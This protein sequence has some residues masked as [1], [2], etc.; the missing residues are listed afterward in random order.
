MNSF[1]F[2][3]QWYSHSLVVFIHDKVWYNVVRKGYGQLKELTTKE[4]ESLR[5]SRL[6][7]ERRRVVEHDNRSTGGARRRGE[8]KQEQEQEVDF[9]KGLETIL[10]EPP[11]SDKK[12]AFEYI[13]EGKTGE[14]IKN[15]VFDKN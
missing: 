9:E 11:P 6:L 10:G 14:E 3:L 13:K 5:G 12:E 7:R 2:I 8:E 1:I 4:K 15:K